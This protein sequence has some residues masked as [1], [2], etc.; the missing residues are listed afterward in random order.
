M[1]FK[2]YDLIESKA[3]VEILIESKWNLKTGSKDSHYDGFFILIESKWN[4]KN[5]DSTNQR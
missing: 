3:D 4:L 2:D 5:S 1:E